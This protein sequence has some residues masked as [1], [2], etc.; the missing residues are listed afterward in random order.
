MTPARAITIAVVAANLTLGTWAGCVYD[1]NDFETPVPERA[2]DFAAPDA[3]TTAGKTTTKRKP[4]RT[5]PPRSHVVNKAS[6]LA[7]NVHPAAD[8][9]DPRMPMPRGNTQATCHITGTLRMSDGRPAG[10]VDLAWRIDFGPQVFKG[11]ASTDDTGRFG[12]HIKGVLEENTVG[13]FTL[14]LGKPPRRGPGLTVTHLT[15]PLMEVFR[16]T[17]PLELPMDLPQ[18]DFDLGVIVLRSLWSSR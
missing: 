13:R 17:L 4:S 11:Y 10:H 6:D 2:K 3:P 16:D 15:L 12:F 18:G 8:P 1:S 14:K 9:T 7:K 5:E